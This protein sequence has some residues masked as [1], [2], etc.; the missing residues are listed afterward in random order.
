MKKW[1]S[2]FQFLH[3]KDLNGNEQM[4]FY[5]PVQVSKRRKMQKPQ[6]M[7]VLGEKKYDLKEK[8][9][10]IIDKC[11]RFIDS[12]ISEAVIDKGINKHKLLR[13]IRDQVITLIERHNIVN[14]SEK[15]DVHLSSN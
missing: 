2:S 4:Y 7:A 13:N 11:E 15:V 6:T 5:Y 10:I 8:K 9:D 1:A 14:F 12:L 3:R